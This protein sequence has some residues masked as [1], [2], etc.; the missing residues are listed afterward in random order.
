M[1]KV[2]TAQRKGQQT[3]QKN[4]HHSS[5][6][7]STDTKLWLTCSRLSSSCSAP[8][9]PLLLIGIS[10]VAALLIMLSVIMHRIC[11]TQTWENVWDSSWLCENKKWEKQWWPINGL[12]K[13][14]LQ[15]L[16]KTPKSIRKIN[17]ITKQAW[18]WFSKSKATTQDR[19]NPQKNGYSTSCNTY[20]HTQSLQWAVVVKWPLYFEAQSVDCFISPTLPDKR[21]TGS[22]HQQ[23]N[24]SN[25]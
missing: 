11:E 20:T 14:R 21:N 25:R 7:L 22:S 19:N 8:V 6:N 4:I 2:I 24:Y 10:I 23:C 1:E 9:S 18:R 5:I 15:S 12:Y 16:L 3:V 17:I 13:E